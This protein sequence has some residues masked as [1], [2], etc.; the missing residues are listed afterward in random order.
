M[1]KNEIR[2]ANQYLEELVEKEYVNEF[3]NTFFEMPM[4]K[5]WMD[6]IQFEYRMIG[7]CLIYEQ[8]KAL[9]S[10]N[11]LLDYAY[12]CGTDLKELYEKEYDKHDSLRGNVFKQT[13]NGTKLLLSKKEG[14]K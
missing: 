12:I 14:N 1:K 11:Y 9:Y 7:L 10:K 3:D 6:D 2:K 13:Y 5:D 8:Q 4:I